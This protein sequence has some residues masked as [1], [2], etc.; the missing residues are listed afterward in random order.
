MSK[1]IFVHG[2][3]YAASEFEEK[4][5]EDGDIKEIAERISTGE[6]LETDGIIELLEFREVDPEFELFVKHQLCDYDLLKSAC[7]YRV[8]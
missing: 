7:I 1:F 8:E 6:E 5:L 3:D 2:E 4:Y